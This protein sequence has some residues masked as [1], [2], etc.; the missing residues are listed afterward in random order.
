MPQ[1]QERFMW[2]EIN[3]DLEM[4]HSG[5]GGKSIVVVR[6]AVKQTKFLQI[7][8]FLKFNKFQFYSM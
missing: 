7:T 2:M 3:F 6:Q 8:K 1:K 4:C 5:L